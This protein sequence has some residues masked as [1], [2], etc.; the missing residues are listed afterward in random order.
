[1]LG[2]AGIIASKRCNNVE[3]YDN[4]VYD[5]GAQAAGIFLH[6]SSDNAKIHGNTIYNMQGRHR[7][8]GVRPWC[9]TR[10]GVPHPLRHSFLWWLSA[11]PTYTSLFS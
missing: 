9:L 6:R 5:G 4:E 3:I 2:A 7:R 8:R 10:K 11:T 1:M